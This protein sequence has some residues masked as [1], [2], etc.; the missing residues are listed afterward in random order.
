MSKNLK[1]RDTF[2]VLEDFFNQCKKTA[3]AKQVKD[4]NGFGY[5]HSWQMY[6]EKCGLPYFTCKIVEDAS[7]FDKTSNPQLLI[8]IANRCAFA[9]EIA[10]RNLR[11]KQLN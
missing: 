2:E 6:A 9:W 1:M 10:R 4:H 8:D 11:T 7:E 3:K 5:K